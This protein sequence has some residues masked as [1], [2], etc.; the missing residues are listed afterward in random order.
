MHVIAR[1]TWK[2]AANS[3]DYIEKY[4]DLRSGSIGVHFLAIMM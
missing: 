4:P 2:G 3:I 1:M